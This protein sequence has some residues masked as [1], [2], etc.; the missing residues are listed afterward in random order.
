[1]RTD[2]PDLNLGRYYLRTLCEADCFDYYEIGR[3]LET[4]KF[5][6]WGPFIN[7]NEAVY[8]IKEFFLTRP[9]NGLPIGY[10]IIDKYNNHK[11]I[12]VIDFHTYYNNTNTAEIGYILNRNYW[13][14]GI[15]KKCLKEVTKIGFNHLMLNKIIVGHTIENEASR[16]V[17]LKCGFH[18]D[19]QTITKIKDEDKL[20]NYYSLYR[21]EYERE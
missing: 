16:H 12:G 5:L 2:L 17:I 1:M 3:D 20:A 9:N 6:N 7:V 14:M 13:N 11:M 21:Y 19:Y 8:A 15:M 10:A 4:V 18:Y